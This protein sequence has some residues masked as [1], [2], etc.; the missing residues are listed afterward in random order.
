MIVACERCHTKFR[1]DENLLKG[2]GSKVRCSIC[3]HKFILFP[4]KTGPQVEEVA[5]ER[6]EEPGALPPDIDKTLVGEPIEEPEAIDETFIQEIEK[7]LAQ[8]E[9]VEPISFEDF[10]A[11]D[12]GIIKGK[13]HAEEID[14]AMDR[15]TKVEEEVRA[16]EEL[17]REGRGRVR[18]AEEAF[19]ARPVIKKRPRSRLWITILLI[20]LLLT[21]TASA[22]IVF[23]PGFLPVSFPLGKK[24]ISKEQAFDMGNRRLSFKDLDG[25]FVDSEKAGKLFMVK[26]LVTNNYP[27]RRSFIRI[28]SNI[29]DSKGTVVK[30]K[31]A[32]A[33]NP[34][35]DKEVRSLSMEDID[36]RLRDRLGKDKMNINVHPNASIPFA[37][38]FGDLPEDMS[39]F[40]VEA[41]SSSPAG[42]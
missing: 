42:K 4:P 10:A 25:S 7:E 17:E 12:S 15:A 13:A 19:E 9:E 28:R 27:D 14:R 35:S 21:G 34:I 11:L 37:I 1:L 32:F 24:P 22:L 31:I 2:T 41:I 33:G 39:E 38:V 36:N 18:E 40:T 3:Q 29:L 5:G 6:L 16:E 26:G 8:E 30:S 20:I 23:K